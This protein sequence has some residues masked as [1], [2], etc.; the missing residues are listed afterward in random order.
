MLTSPLAI[1]AA[2]LALQAA[3]CRSNDAA[4]APEVLA[5]AP[6][7]CIVACGERIDI[8]APVVL[9]TDPDGYSAYETDLH[10]EP[11][12]VGVPR[13]RPGKLR[14]RPGRAD[15][16]T[17]VVEVEP[18]VGTIEQLEGALDLLV[19]HYDAG[20]TSQTCFETLH[21]VRGLSVQFMLDVDGTLYQCLD[22][23]DTAWHAAQAN[24]RSVGVEIAHPGAEVVGPKGDAFI[25]RFYEQDEG[26][27]R[28]DLPGSPREFGVRTPAYV[29]RPQR[30]GLKR[31][32]I[33]GTL[34]QQYDYT[35][36]Q[37]D[38]LVKLTAALCRT[39]PNLEPE[40]PRDD[41]GRVLAERLDPEAE[42]RFHG[43][44]G[45]YHVSSAKRDPGPAFDWELFLTRVRARVGGR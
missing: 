11:P 21:D 4:V 10:F 25:A 15:R 18:E 35:K 29:V 42:K 44:V 40:V 3:A 8:G 22:L 7:T 12:P 31:G 24:S 36:E 30:A 2:A 26:G 43:I 6:N 28:L 23:R 9:W 27:P 20:W 1:A 38:T 41:E 45:H 14:Y 33:H 39:F 32:R 17:G 19:V 16:D 37:Y 34:Y 5:G 13:A